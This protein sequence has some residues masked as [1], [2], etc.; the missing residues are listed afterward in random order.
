M[1]HFRIW[2]FI[3]ILSLK[4]ISKSRRREKY[5]N[6]FW[7][8]LV[9]DIE[10]LYDTSVNAWWRV[11]WKRAW[12]MVYWNAVESEDKYCYWCLSEMEKQRAIRVQSWLMSP[13]KEAWYS[14]LDANRECSWRL[15]ANPISFHLFIYLSLFQLSMVIF[16]HQLPPT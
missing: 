14:H 15:L 8:R 6:W 10:I 9:N 13:L 1:S 5:L 11:F 3:T 4:N 12:M 16:V 7:F 2:N